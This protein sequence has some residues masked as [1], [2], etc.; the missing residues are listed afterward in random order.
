MPIGTIF[1]GNLSF[2]CTEADLRVR[3]ETIG[4]VHSVIIRR[5]KAG[6]MLYY[7]FVQMKGP[8]DAKRAVEQLHNQK[9]LGRKLR[10]V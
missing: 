4:P 1:V 8:N 5:T 2:F 10:Y 7:G 6:E 9:F 3:F